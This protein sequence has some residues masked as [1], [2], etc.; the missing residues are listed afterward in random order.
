MS[1]LLE[2]F[3]DQIAYHEL[4]HVLHSLSLEHHTGIHH[5]LGNHLLLVLA[6]NPSEDD[7]SVRLA[8]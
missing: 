3:G 2:N 7:I 4:H 5:I 6:A 8:G 1:S